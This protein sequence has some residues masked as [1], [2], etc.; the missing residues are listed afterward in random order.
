MY[1]KFDIFNKV[2]LTINYSFM[3][4]F[5]SVLTKEVSSRK[6]VQSFI[7][8]NKKSKEKYATPNSLYT[9]LCKKNKTKSFLLHNLPPAKQTYMVNEWIKQLSSDDKDKLNRDVKILNDFILE[10]ESKL[11]K[12]KGKSF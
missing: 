3:H 2:N 1:L 5:N 7:N 9:Y 12:S 11:I 4:M 8:S 10:E 6:F